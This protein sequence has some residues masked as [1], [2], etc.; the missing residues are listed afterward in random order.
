MFV[1]AISDTKEFRKECAD[2]VCGVGERII[3]DETLSTLFDLEQYLYPSLFE[4]QAPVVYAQFMLEG[5][6]TELTPSF[7]QKLSASPTVFFF[8]EFTLP[9]TFITTLKKHGAIVHQSKEK[10][11]TKKSDDIFALASSIITLDKKKS[12]LAFRAAIEKQPVEA[13]LGIMYWKVRDVMLK[14]KSEEYKKL[15]TK[16]MH[17][18]MAAW[19]TNTPLELL[20]EKALLTP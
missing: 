3:I 4:T 1:I 2:S 17:A 5:K 19:R 8:E 18:H 14:Q 15:Y 11:V 7:I 16:L 6:N 12:W 9:T 13:L 10:K 20:I